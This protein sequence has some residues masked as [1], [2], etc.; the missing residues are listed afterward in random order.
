MIFLTSN[1]FLAQ[2]WSKCKPQCSFTKFDFDIT[3]TKFPNPGFLKNRKAIQ[4][5]GTHSTE[6]GQKN[7]AELVINMA[8]FSVK[9][10]IV[11]PKYEIFS[12]SSAIGGLFGMLLGGS[13]LTMYELAELCTLWVS[14]CFVGIVRKCA[15]NNNIYP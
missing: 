1:F 11:Y 4:S 2:C 10:T 6:Y 9:H 14:A 8:S 3:S 7:Y 12:A 15:N 5:A 13:A